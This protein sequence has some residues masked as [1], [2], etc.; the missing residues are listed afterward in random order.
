M[1]AGL[2]A[3]GDIS[4]A[5]WMAPMALALLTSPALSVWTSRSDLGRMARVRGLFLTPDETARPTE[6]ADL[7]QIRGVPAEAR[8]ALP[9][10]GLR[11]AVA[12]D[13]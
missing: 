4:L 2:L 3:A 8:P 9:R 11:L 5:L 13:A 12:D 10:P 6:L 1:S 7:A